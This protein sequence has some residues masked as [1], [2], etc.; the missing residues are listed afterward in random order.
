[1]NMAWTRVAT[2]NANGRGQMLRYILKV[3]GF[4]HK[5]EVGEKSKISLRLLD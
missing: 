4:A 1:M 2:V 3:I 5:C